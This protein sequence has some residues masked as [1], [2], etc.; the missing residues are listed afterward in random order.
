M[1]HLNGERELLIPHGT[2]LVQARLGAHRVAV[3]A[4]DDE[5]IAHAAGH[6]RLR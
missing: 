4:D 1:T 3:E 2:R 5:S 6:L